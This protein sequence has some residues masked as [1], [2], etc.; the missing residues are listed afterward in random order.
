MS[1]D[2][3]KLATESHCIVEAEELC[4]TLM[5]IEWEKAPTDSMTSGLLGKSKF[6]EEK[7]DITGKT[8]SISEY[9]KGK[10]LLIIDIDDNIE[11]Q[12]KEFNPSTIKTLFYLKKCLI[13]QDPLIKDKDIAQIQNQGNFPVTFKVSAY[14]ERRGMKDYKEAKRQLKRDVDI[15]Y[16]TSLNFRGKII[17]GKKQRKGTLE[18]RILTSKIK[19]QNGNV[20]VRVNGDF[21]ESLVRQGLYWTWLP[22]DCY[23]EKSVN[24]EILYKLCVHAS[25]NEKR[26]KERGFSIISIEALL[27]AVGSIPSYE[28]VKKRYSRHV[29]GKIITPLEKALTE[30]QDKNYLKWQFANAKGKPLTTEQSCGLN[31]KGNL[32]EIKGKKDKYYLNWENFKKLYIRY[33][34]LNKK[35]VETTIETPTDN[36]QLNAACAKST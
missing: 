8:K 32:R 22:V 5:D 21:V 16:D 1:D 4:S 24:F 7:K 25:T 15:L 28:D 6:L 10:G 35:P 13:D 3:S 17:E 18:V 14:K 26:D 19:I 29:E 9:A 34:L 2:K 23:K 31:R 36:L 11:N 33:N 12:I 30:L 20:T 27:E